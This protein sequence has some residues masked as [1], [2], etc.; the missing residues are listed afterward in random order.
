VTAGLDL[1]AAGLTTD[2]DGFVAV[3][4]RRETS[5]DGIYA[6]G[7]VAGEPMLAHVASAEGIVAAEAIAGE[8]T[9]FDARSIPAAVFTDPEVATV[10]LSETEAADEGFDPVVGKMPFSAS[11]RALTTGETEGFVEVVASEDG[12]LLGARIVGNEASELI[13]E[14]ALAIEMGA[15]LTDVASTIHT[16]PTLSEAVM[17]AAENAM[18][19]AIHT[20]NR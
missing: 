9:V 20:L 8:Q 10:G 18:E 11:G 2:R 16:H 7:D 19:Q 6:V 3:D 15:R 14:P 1:E 13:A 17:E 4:E 12:T 5:V